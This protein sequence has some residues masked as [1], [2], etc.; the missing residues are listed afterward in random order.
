MISHITNNT[1]LV[2]MPEKGSDE[3]IDK[4]MNKITPKLKLTE[5]FEEYDGVSYFIF[6]ISY[7]F[8]VLQPSYLGSLL[9]PL[10]LSILLSYMDTIS[11]TKL[12]QCCHLLRRTVISTREYRRRVNR[13]MSK[14]VLLLEEKEDKQTEEE[15]SYYYKRK[16]VQYL[17]R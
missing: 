2:C 13:M 5:N 17:G 1:L 4:T 9:P 3:T 6:S 11:L 16:I 14:D 8:F 15:N 12:E 10:I 7:R